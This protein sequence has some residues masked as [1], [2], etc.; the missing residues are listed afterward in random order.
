MTSPS[1]PTPGRRAAGI[2]TPGAWR[3]LCGGLALVLLLL[4][5][6]PAWAQSVAFIN[7]GR[8]GEAFWVTVTRS[9]EAAARSLGMRLE[10]LYAEREFPRAIA[11]AQQI[12]QRPAAEL[13]DYVIV[14]NEGG[15]GPELVRVLAPRTKVF[16]AFSG[17]P[18]GAE[19]QVGQGDQRH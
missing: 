9:M 4:G 2:A 3:G 16:V 18:P 12:A 13:P 17:I 5:P 7:P 19:G 8:S 11:L 10:V 14:A 6:A 1:E 15:A